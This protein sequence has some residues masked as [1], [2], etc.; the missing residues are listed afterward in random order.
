MKQMVAW[1]GFMFVLAAF[2]AY[3]LYHSER[4]AK[5]L[6][7]T[8]EAGGTDKLSADDPA[9]VARIRRRLVIF[10]AVILVASLLVNLKSLM[11][12]M[13]LKNRNQVAVQEEQVAVTEE[14]SSPSGYGAGATAPA[15]PNNE[16]HVPPSKQPPPR[17]Q[18]RTGQAEIPMVLVPG[19]TFWMGISDDEKDRAIEDCKTE[20][21]KHAASCTG[22]VL[23]AQPR[24]QVTLD[25]FFL[26]PYEVTNRQF[27]QFVQATAYQTTAEKG[28]TA[29][30][31]DGQRWPET[32]GATWRQPEAGPDVFASDRADHPVV[33]VSWHDAEAYCRWVG[34]RLP[35]EAEF[36]YA[37]RAGTQ[38]TYWWGNFSPGTRQVANVADESAKSRHSVIMA[39]HEDGAVTTAPVGSYEANPFGLFDMTGNV[40]EWTADRYDGFYYRKSPERNPTGP[41][42]GDYRMIRGGGWNDALFG[43]RPT[44][45]DG[46]APTK[47]DTRTGFRCA[48][49][50]PK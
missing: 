6:L 9:A 12:L 34:K 41:S 33:N 35:T 20:F 27:E 42:S 5:R 40:A 21:K 13:D 28:G 17:S 48:Q 49:D 16:A 8:K 18:T 3:M 43:I 25:P 50:Q 46:G 14:T 2:C 45:R 29:S 38:T 24:H 22:L 7:T 10:Y 11:V 39:G 1:M 36:E 37:T 15:R 32:K 4:E 30:I 19:G 44:V 31:W 47:R 23:S 26:D